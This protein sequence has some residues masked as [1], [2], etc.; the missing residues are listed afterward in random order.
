[1]ADRLERVNQAMGKENGRLKSQFKTQQDD[2]EFLIKELVTV[3]K[4][5]FLTS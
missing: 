3:R 5:S 4:V 2:R 1:M